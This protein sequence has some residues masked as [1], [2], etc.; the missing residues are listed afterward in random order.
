M[1][2]S[3]TASLKDVD[4]PD[5]PVLSLVGLARYLGLPYATL[6]ASRSRCPDSLPPPFHTRPLRWRRQTVDRWLAAR[7]HEEEQRIARSL[8]PVSRRTAADTV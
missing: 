2:T 3:Q 8:Q 6:K 5:S 4:S 1:Q 7:E